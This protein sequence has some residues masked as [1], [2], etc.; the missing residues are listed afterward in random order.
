MKLNN[1]YISSLIYLFLSGCSFYSIKG[2]IPN[3]L[4][5]VVIDPI[6]ND[7]SE[8]TIGQK[9]ENQFIQSLINE[10]LLRISDFENADSKLEFKITDLSDKPY[11]LNETNFNTIVEQWEIIITIEFAWFDLINQVDIV[12]KNIKE[13]IVYDLNNSNIVNNSFEN[14]VTEKTSIVSSR[15]EAVEKCILNLSD[16]VITELTSTW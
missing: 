10:N 1:I 16:R 14:D 11:T 15:Q 7:S 13:S 5:T 6:I 8:Y 9:F 12:N 4:N 2:S 3:H